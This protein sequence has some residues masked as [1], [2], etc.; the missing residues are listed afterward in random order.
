MNQFSFNSGSSVI[1]GEENNPDLFIRKTIFDVGYSEK[2]FHNHPNS[3]EFYLVLEGQLTFANEQEELLATEGSIV[4]FAKAEKHKIT[5]VS[6][7]TT[8]LLFKKV[9]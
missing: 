5:S 1:C 3:F 7:K 6:K 2:E 4:Y 8:M 9:G